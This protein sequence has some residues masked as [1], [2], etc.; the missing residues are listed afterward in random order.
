MFSDGVDFP[1][2]QSHGAEGEVAHPG[3]PLLAAL[4]YSEHQTFRESYG[5]GQRLVAPCTSCFPRPP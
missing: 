1:A 2:Y 5:V 4:H 3:E